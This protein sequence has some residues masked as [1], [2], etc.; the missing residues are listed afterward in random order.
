MSTYTPPPGS[1]VDLPLFGDYAP[2][3]GDVVALPLGEDLGEPPE[4][5]EQP[6]DIS[7]AMPWRDTVR[8]GLEL[9]FSHGL[10][11]GLEISRELGHRAGQPVEDSTA[12]TWGLLQPL[13]AHR[14]IG[15]RDTVPLEQ[16]TAIS[17]RNL[18]PVEIARG[19]FWRDTSP[20]ETSTE[21]RW[22]LATPSEI[23]RSVGW[24]DTVAR[25][26]PV[27]SRWLLGT[28]VYPDWSIPWGFAKPPR[29]LVDNPNIDRPV[30]PT[31]QPPPVYTPPPGDQ[32]DLPFTCRRFDGPGDQVALPFRKYQCL[33]SY[34]VVENDLILKRA[35]DDAEVACLQLDISGDLD[36][37]TN[38]WSAQVHVTDFEQLV[39][40]TDTGPVEV[41]A[42]ING[43]DHLLLLERFSRDQVFDDVRGKVATVRV[44]GRSVSAELDEPY[45]ARKSRFEAQVKS[46]WQLM[47][48]ELPL[49]TDWTLEAHPAWSAY[50]D[51][52]TQTVPA[53]TFSYT[54]LS[55]IQA[56]ARIAEATGAVVQQVPAE[57]TLKIVPRYVAKPWEWANTTADLEIDAG[58]LRSSGLEFEPAVLHNGVYVSGETNGVLVECRRNGTAGAPWLDMVVDQLITDPQHALQRGIKELGSTGKRQVYALELPVDSNEDGLI[59]TGNLVNVVE[60]VTTDWNGQAIAWSLSGTWSE[61]RG[62]EIW[63]RIAVE[64][65][66]DE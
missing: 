36:S 50:G 63:Q 5:S 7:R 64:R 56:I 59:Q 25:D 8:R 51:N 30:P 47:Q 61:G 58:Q 15:W 31:P 66:R 54:D 1:E 11:A 46:H 24:R 16:S 19:L 57:R 52:I 48:Q 13:E 22:L 12:L 28:M 43:E 23:S 53:N 2:P 35:S 34:H 33:R 6:I 41:V 55:P 40:P 20:L 49:G 62:L 10:A 4:P 38:A 60:S 3:D 37:Y 9:T 39:D 32:V 17:W 65:Y 18:T 45:S 14:A 42:T 29:T 27:E 26:M 21:A 44:Q